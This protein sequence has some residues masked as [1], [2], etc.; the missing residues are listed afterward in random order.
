[1]REIISIIMPAYNAEE[2]ITESINSILRQTFTEF[3]LYIINDNS[4]DSTKKIIQKIKDPRIVYL[5]NENNSGV[6]ESRNKGIRCCQGTFIAFLDSDD[7]WENKK[8]ELQYEKLLNGWDVVCSAYKTFTD[9]INDIKGVRIPP[10][11]IT[12]D[13]MFKSNFVGNLTGIYNAEKFGKIYQKKIG[14]EDYVMWL[15]IIKRAG[16]AFCIQEPLAFYRISSNSL[17]GNKIKAAH[18]QWIIYRD[19]QKLSFVKSVYYFGFYIAYAIL[20]RR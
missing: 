9:Q 18:W 11:I 17:S 20:K 16:K 3:K 6:S 5:E 7:I 12:C 15:E 1:M 2:T 13:D 19:I 14:H 10:Q 4:S 8:L